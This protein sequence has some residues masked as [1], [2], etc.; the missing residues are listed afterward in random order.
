MKTKLYL[1]IPLMIFL[2]F[3]YQT[4]AQNLSTYG[5]ADNEVFQVGSRYHISF[6]S[7]TPNVFHES[8]VT[9]TEDAEAFAV[10]SDKQGNLKLYSNGCHIW[11]G[12]HQ[13]LNTSSNVLPDSVCPQFTL[14]DSMGNHI[15][16]TAI[17]MPGNPDLIYVFSLG[18]KDIQPRKLYYSLVD[19]ST[20][21]S[22]IIV[23]GQEFTKLP[24]KRDLAVT[25]HTNGQ[26]YWLVTREYHKNTY[27]A[28]RIRPGG[29]VDTVYSANTGITP[30][31][32]GYDLGLNFSPNGR[33]LGEVINLD[34]LQLLQFDASTGTVSDTNMRYIV[35]YGYQ[36]WPDR[37]AFSPDNSK[38]YVNHHNLYTRFCQYDL[39]T[40]AQSQL[41]NSRILLFDNQ[42][43]Y[44]NAGCLHLTA[45]RNIYNPFHTYNTGLAFN[46]VENP[47]I[48]DT[49]CNWNTAN[50]IVDS[51]AYVHPSSFS[52]NFCSAWL[53]EPVD[54]SYTH[55]CAG[56][57]A[58]PTLFAFTDSVYEAEWHFGDSLAGGA[59]TSSALYPS[60]KYP[61]PGQYTVWVKAL[62]YGMWDSIAKTVTIYQN[63]QISLGKDTTLAANDT[64]VLDPGSG[65]VSYNWNTGDTT[66]TLTLYGSQ[67]TGGSH[68][69]W[70]EVTDSNGCK[71]KAYRTI[72]Y[73]GVGIN[74]QNADKWKVYPN[75][76]EERLTIELN[77]AIHEKA[78]LRLYNQHGAIVRRHQWPKQAKTQHLSLYGLSNG[79]YWMELDIEQRK[80]RQKVVKR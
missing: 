71:D 64:L 54:F 12:N 56:E 11:N 20:G 34:T 31:S 21:Q 53:Q 18:R 40:N 62:H 17:P 57:N 58:Q 43:T 9:N 61:Q 60:Y 16:S 32:W 66:Q 29:N 73:S 13:P 2:D 37:F 42:I 25:K 8:F 79:I 27:V 72:T 59:D 39:S 80:Y 48:G 78:T 5:H 19:I 10:Y 30:A 51:S 1:L 49:N 52:S 33:I 70:V 26:D 46:S 65:Y 75:P 14:N 76:A 36:L 38:L 67:M 44:D 15:T 4:K 69:Y 74:E 28:F 35:N 50:F 7:D 47:N 68:S 45:N 22:Q 3:S 41:L 77:H 63:P 23:S 55:T 6:Q 24:L